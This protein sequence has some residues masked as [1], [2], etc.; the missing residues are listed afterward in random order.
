MFAKPG[1]GISQDVGFS[2]DV[3]YFV[4]GNTLNLGYNPEMLRIR[5]LGQVLLVHLVQPLAVRVEAEFWGVQDV[6][7]TAF[8]GI[9]EGGDLTIDG[10]KTN[11]WW[12]EI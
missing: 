8:D 1:E 2:R 6:V 11:L 5:Y 10:G 4:K 9:G 7:V 3:C 12:E